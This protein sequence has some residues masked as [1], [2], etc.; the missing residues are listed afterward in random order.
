VSRRT[1]APKSKSRLERLR[2]LP[3]AA[4]LQAALLVGKRWRALS[5]RDRARIARLVRESRGRLGNL[6]RRERLELQLL[7]RK[8]RL[9]ALPGELI[10][11]VRG[12]RRRRSRWRRARA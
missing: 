7:L 12:G 4:L 10:L 2:V 3:W 9:R 1:V 5:Q 8:L 6:D 11:I